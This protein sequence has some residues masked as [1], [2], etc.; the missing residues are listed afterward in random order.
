MTCRQ[1][2]M[3]LLAAIVPMRRI[4]IGEVSAKVYHADEKMTHMIT[5]P[6]T[7]LVLTIYD[8][9]LNNCTDPEWCMGADFKKKGNVD[10]EEFLFAE[11]RLGNNG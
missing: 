2:L 3:T 4:I 1:I 11:Y 7:L 10:I 9:Q 5:D 6:Y 8:C